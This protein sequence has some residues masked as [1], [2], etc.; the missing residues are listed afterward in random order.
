MATN[1]LKGIHT[2]EHLD[3]KI[4]RYST[5]T[6]QYPDIFVQRKRNTGELIISTDTDPYNGMHHIYVGGE[7]IASGYGFATVKTRNDLT[8]IQETYNGVFN[9]LN[10][11]Y[12]YLDSAYTY[13][14]DFNKKSYTYVLQSLLDNS[15]T[16]V[17]VNDKLN[18]ITINDDISYVLSTSNVILSLETNNKLTIDIYESYINAIEDELKVIKNNNIT[19][20]LLSND[21]NDIFS[22]IN[23]NV[24]IGSLTFNLVTKN[25]PFKTVPIIINFRNTNINIIKINYNIYDS[26]NTIASN[27]VA[28]STGNKN[29]FENSNYINDE[30]L[31]DKDYFYIPVFKDGNNI[32]NSAL[33][34]QYKLSDESEIYTN[35]IFF[36]WITPTIIY[37]IQKNDSV[38][39]PI[40]KENNIINIDK[41]NSIIKCLFID[42]NNITDYT[43]LNYYNTDYITYCFKPINNDVNIYISNDVYKKANCQGGFTYITTAYSENNKNEYTIYSSE[44]ISGVYNSVLRFDVDY[45]YK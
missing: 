21:F 37:N 32:Y 1:N 45:Q 14:S 33:N 8:Y 11:G 39:I 19:Y 34:I 27:W 31:K 23:T 38:T 15:Y 44:T 17:S 2:L 16:N 10:N 40:I 4:V 30:L 12:N 28:G 18:S 9:Y 26:L 41:N 36:K 43:T 5:I 3:G 25:V 6:T 7:H 22:K 35:T 29:D 42:N 20:T 24:N 13:M